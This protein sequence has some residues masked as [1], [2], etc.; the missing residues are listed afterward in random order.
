MLK[1]ASDFLE[2]TLSDFSKQRMLMIFLIFSLITV[3]LA[4]YEF[5]TAKFQ[6]DKYEDSIALLKSIENLDNSTVESKQI[7]NDIYKG[8]SQITNP[9][10]LAFYRNIMLTNEMKQ[11]LW[12]ILPWV[13]VILVGLPTS[14]SQDGSI[15]AFFVISFI[16]LFLGFVGY[17]LPTQWNPWLVSGLIS[18]GLNVI[19]FVSIVILE[20]KISR[21]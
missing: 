1:S 13:V 7:I 15:S 6:I 17:M 5:M 20:R 3:G 2:K 19:V 8:I 18:Q 21:E 14:F 4:S 10:S 11:A 9:S 16:A 12:A